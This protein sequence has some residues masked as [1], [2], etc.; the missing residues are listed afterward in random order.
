MTITSHTSL[1]VTSHSFPQMKQIATQFCSRIIIIYLPGDA[2]AGIHF[3]H[4]F[5]CSAGYDVWAVSVLRSF[6]FQTRSNFGQTSV[7][8]TGFYYIITIQGRIKKRPCLD[9]RR[10]WPNTPPTHYSM[11]SVSN[12]FPHPHSHPHPDPDPDPDPDPHIECQILRMN[13]Y[14]HRF[15]TISP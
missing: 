13:Y 4:P 5:W 2:Y 15:G 11:S 1:R 10:V 9:L 12:D 3:L 8:V 6:G 7:A 14:G